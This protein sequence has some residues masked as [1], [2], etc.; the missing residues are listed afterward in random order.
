M[1]VNNA[2]VY[3]DEDISI[4]NIDEGVMEDTFATNYFGPYYTMKTFH[5]LMEKEGYGRCFL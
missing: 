3:L 2:G 4:K 5:P 1:L